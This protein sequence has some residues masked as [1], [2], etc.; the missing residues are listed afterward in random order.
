MDAH[1]TILAMTSELSSASKDMYVMSELLQQAAKYMM[2]QHEEII[3]LK[4][5]LK[6]SEQSECETESE[7]ETDCETESEC[8]TEC[9]TESD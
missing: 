4:R 6:A 5:Q 1:S 7:C 2:A 8:E 3:E 9:E